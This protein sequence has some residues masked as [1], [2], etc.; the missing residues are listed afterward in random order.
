M[1]NIFEE[2]MVEIFP[3]VLKTKPIDLESQQTPSTRNI[4]EKNNYSK[5]I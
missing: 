4:E 3:S 2:I 1:E 5:S